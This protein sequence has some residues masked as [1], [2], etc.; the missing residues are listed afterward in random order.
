MKKLMASSFLGLGIGI[1]CVIYS[2]HYSGNLRSFMNL[3]SFLI[4]A[5]GT[6]GALILA[7]P[8]ERLKTLGSVI[9]RAFKKDHIDL[10]KDIE[11]ILELS[12][13]AKKNGT[14]AL[15]NLAKQYDN[16]EFLQKG[17]YLLADG[18]AEDM[19]IASMQ[20]DIYFAQKR[21]KQGHAMIDLI[22]SSVTSLGLMGTYIGLIPMLEH[23][24]DPT[25]LGPLMAIELVTS[26]Y[27]AFLSYVIFMPLSRKLKNMSSEEALRKE[28]ILEGLVDIQKGKN[29]RIIQEELV[30][31]LTKKQ[32]KTMTKNGKKSKKPF[33][34]K[35]KKVA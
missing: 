11:T 27:G 32:A 33:E 25:S 34:F 29:P 9:A 21:H 23:L 12:E 4:I 30:A 13:F 20:N 18:L 2:I 7:F 19:L 24:E 6:A 5:G 1:F 31:C 22:A 28:I 3:P 15:E 16:D 14:L 8:F 26:F 10:Q 17:I 35:G